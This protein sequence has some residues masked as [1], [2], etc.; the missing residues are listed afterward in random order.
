M[1]INTYGLD[2]WMNATIFASDV[3]C[4]SRKLKGSLKGKV[5][6]N[7]ENLPNVT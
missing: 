2:K 4:G 1:S 6:K 3:I 5:T 7:W